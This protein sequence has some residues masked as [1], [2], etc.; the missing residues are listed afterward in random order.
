[1]ILNLLK[2]SGNSLLP[3]YQDGDFVL[4]SKIPYL[5][6]PIRPG[7]VVVFRREPYGTLIKMVE[8]LGAR[9]DEISVVGTFP[10]SVDSTRFGP[11]RARKVLG[12][13]IWHIKR[14]GRTPV[15]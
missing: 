8:S 1:V 3:A 5:F 11:I 9:G 15:S 12:K 4:V 14:P 13:V 10:G 2:V 6:A 7:D